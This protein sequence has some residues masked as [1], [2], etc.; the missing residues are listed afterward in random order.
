MD[1]VKK[2]SNLDLWNAARSRGLR[3]D[4][5]TSLPN[6]PHWYKRML[7]KKNKQNKSEQR[8]CVTNDIKRRHA[9]QQLDVCYWL[10]LMLV[11]T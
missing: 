2:F 9:L 7:R 4:Y 6:I 8:F 5:N 10:M 1:E 11:F 3:L